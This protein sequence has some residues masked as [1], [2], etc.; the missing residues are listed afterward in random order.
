VQ[1]TNSCLPA[2][3]DWRKRRR[4]PC[5]RPRGPTTLPAGA[6]A[7]AATCQDAGHDVQEEGLLSAIRRHRLRRRWGRLS[8]LRGSSSSK[9]LNAES[10]TDLITRPK[11]V[12]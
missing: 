1:W 12:I 9:G 10:V 8:K 3:T 5:R 6:A 7:A 2:F 4:T 11:I